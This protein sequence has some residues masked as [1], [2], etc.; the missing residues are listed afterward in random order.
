MYTKGFVTIIFANM[1]FHLCLS[2]SIPYKGKKSFPQI[3][4]FHSSNAVCPGGKPADVIILLDV[5]K[6]LTTEQFN[7]QISRAEHIVRLFRNFNAQDKHFNRITIIGVSENGS[8]TI[9]KFKKNFKPNYTEE[10]VHVLRKL[11]RNRKYAPSVD[12]HRKKP[13][14]R[15]LKQILKIH[16]KLR[17][18]VAQVAFYFSADRTASDIDLKRA[19]RIKKKGIYLYILRLG[20]SEI[21]FDQY[22]AMVQSPVGLFVFKANRHNAIDSS[23][24]PLLNMEHCN[25]QVSPGDSSDRSICEAKRSVDLLLGVVSPSHSKSVTGFYESLNKEL[26]NSN[27]KKIEIELITSG[28]LTENESDI[29]RY[30]KLLRKVQKS[31]INYGR[32]DAQK[33]LLLFMKSNTVLTEK[34]IK[35]AENLKNN[36]IE[37]YAIIEGKSSTDFSKVVSRIAKN[38]LFLVPHFKK[39]VGYQDT[40]LKSI[41]QGW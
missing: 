39:L 21:T 18:G 25:M 13:E 23:V 2:A 19:A 35:E 10:I 1:V 9:I 32:K 27:G 28:P 8:N 14:M 5:S 26:K 38:H 22:E 33:T 15:A 6:Y 3:R 24:K 41:C 4:T 12:Q 17:K 34:I 7:V 29:D 30:V 31:V 36:K 16:R 11:R 37:I 20:V 40:V